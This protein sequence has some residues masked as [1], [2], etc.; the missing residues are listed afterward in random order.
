MKKRF[1][2][3]IKI[4]LF[5][6]LSV[7]FMAFS[8]GC[9]E[10]GKVDQGRT[11]AY[12]KG[13]GEFT[14]IE[15]RNYADPKNP[16]YSILP[17]HTYKVPADP[18]EMGAEPKPGLRMKLDTKNN[19]ITIFDTATQN[20][21]TID[22]KLI[23]QKENVDPKDPLVYDKAADKAKKFPLVDREKKTITLYSKR[24]KTLTTFTLPDEYFAL[25][26][27]T[28][29]AGDE[30]RIYYKEKGV[31]LRVMNITKTDIFKK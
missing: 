6:V 23:E 18:G 3:T 27:Y 28:W 24:L 20:F 22:Y 9:G 16:D 13:K 31:A 26:D 25:P 2:L 11:I 21:K 29:D 5:A 14:I 19:Q 10:L 12:D 8:F 15:D 1:G 17:P 7:L 30:L 4:F